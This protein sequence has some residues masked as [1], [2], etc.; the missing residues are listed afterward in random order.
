MTF[1]CRA[2]TYDARNR[3]NASERTDDG[4][5]LAGLY[6]VANLPD[7]ESGRTRY[8]F[9]GDVC[10]PRGSDRNSGRLGHYPVKNCMNESCFHNQSGIP[11]Q[12]VPSH[13][14]RGSGE[15]NHREAAPSMGSIGIPPYSPEP[16]RKAMNDF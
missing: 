16:S 14:C 2:P 11:E 12:R 13:L 10:S 9:R 4:G 3:G 5:R 15:A 1:K 7:P 6:S 8:V